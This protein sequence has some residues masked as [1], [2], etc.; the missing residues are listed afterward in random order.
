MSPSP[1]SKR[2]ERIDLAREVQELQGSNARLHQRNTNLHEQNHFATLKMA[3][4]EEKLTAEET[5]KEE[6][7]NK[8]DDIEYELTKC[9]MRNGKLETTLAETQVSLKI[10][11][12]FLDVG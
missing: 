2:I 10:G 1:L 6:L 11:S 8:V 12:M 5:R 4:I 3:A 9:R 7:Q